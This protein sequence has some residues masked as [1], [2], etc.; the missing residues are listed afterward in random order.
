M[1]TGDRGQNSPT[2]HARAETVFSIERDA[3]IILLPN[4]ADKI[5]QEVLKTSGHAQCF[6][7]P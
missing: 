7:V 4:M 1:A 3:V 6:H 5:V 2:V